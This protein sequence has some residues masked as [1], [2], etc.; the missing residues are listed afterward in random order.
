MTAANLRNAYGGESMAHM[1][2]GIWGDKAE[3]EG[4]PNIAR[5]LRAI[6][7]AETVHAT[8]HF[9]ELGSELGDALCASGAVFGLGPTTQNLQ[10]GI[11]GETF[12]ITEMYPVYL[13]GAKFQEEKGAVKS[14]NWALEGEKTHVAL[15]QKGKEAADAAKDADIGP[16]QVCGVCGWTHEGDAPDACPVC[17]AKK[18]KFQTFA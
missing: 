8:S 18:E 6:A 16:L 11:D 13:E 9:R 14:F 7:A 17:G 2:Y 5:M 3:K 1:R 15:F 10:G 4:F 12:E